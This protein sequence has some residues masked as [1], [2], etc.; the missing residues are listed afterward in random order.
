MFDVGRSMF[1]VFPT[2]FPLCA[3]CASL[4]PFFLLSSISPFM[5]TL[6]APQLQ[7]PNHLT[8]SNLDVSG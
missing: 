8:I 6:S 4:R 5:P 2:Y 1:D 3:F 7:T